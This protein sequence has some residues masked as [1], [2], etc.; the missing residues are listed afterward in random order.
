[1]SRRLR[2]RHMPSRVESNRKPE[3]LDREAIAEQFVGGLDAYCTRCGRYN[4]PNAEVY[5]SVFDE[6]AVFCKECKAREVEDVE[7]SGS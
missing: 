5:P 1:M 2:T 6:D 7:R 3:V 4:D